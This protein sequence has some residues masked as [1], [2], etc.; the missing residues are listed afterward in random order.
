TGRDAGE[1]FTVNLPLEVGAVDEDYQLVFSR[2][3]LPVVRQF[4]PD[5]LVVSAGF[6]AHERDPLGGMRVTTPAFAAMTRDLRA[7][8]E[9]CC[10]GR[11]VAAVE[12]GY[13]LQAL[14][15]SLDA[16]IEALAGSPQPA[17]W[18]SS[19]IRSARGEAAVAATS[20]AIRA[21]WRV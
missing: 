11:I 13:D 4:E 1:G 5:L 7:V 19:G 15:A 17:V 12:G 18:P 2:I 14:G 6:D 16:T 10:R 20:T 3:V 21:F 8:A 9:D